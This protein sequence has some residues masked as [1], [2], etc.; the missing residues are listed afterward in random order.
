[1][2]AALRWTIGVALLLAAAVVLYDRVLKQTPLAPVV[3]IHV[4]LVARLHF[5]GSVPEVH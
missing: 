3:A 2:G 5:S 4:V 1:M